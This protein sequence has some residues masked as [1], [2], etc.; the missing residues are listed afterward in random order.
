MAGAGIQQPPTKI[1]KMIGSTSMGFE[2]LYS[3][4]FQRVSRINLVLV[5]R[6]LLLTIGG[7]G[8]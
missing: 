2:P 1:E 4:I 8:G 5:Q 6:L 7:L 3:L